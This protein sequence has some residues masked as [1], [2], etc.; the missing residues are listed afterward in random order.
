VSL[1]I[2]DMNGKQVKVL[3]DEFRDSG[4]HQ[5]EWDARD[6]SGQL[7]PAGIY[8]FRIQSGTF[9]EMKTMSRIY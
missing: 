7:V 3:V 9:V 4:D 1:I 6:E 5:I 8:Y 2:Y